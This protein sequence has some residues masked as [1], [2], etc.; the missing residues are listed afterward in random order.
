MNTSYFF[1][2]CF[3]YEQAYE[4]VSHVDTAIGMTDSISDNATCAFTAQFYSSLG[5]GHSV[6][7]ALEQAKGVMMLES[8]T[9]ANIPMLYTKDDIDTIQ[10]R[11]R[12]PNSPCKIFFGYVGL[13]KKVIRPGIQGHDPLLCAGTFG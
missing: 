2:A 3:S 8:P 5:F 13:G 10:F 6:K 7:K 4:V 11:V 12:G 1:N 9:E